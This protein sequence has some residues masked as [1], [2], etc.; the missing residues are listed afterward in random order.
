MIDIQDDEFQVE[1]PRGLP[2]PLPQDEAILWQSQPQWTALA[3]SAFHVVK[4]TAY[5]G[6]LIAWNTADGWVNGEGLGPIVVS[7]LRL[8]SVGAVAV[9]IL[10]LLAW[11]YA[12]STIYT[13]TDKRVIIRSGLAV[14]MT[15]NLPLARIEAAAVTR[16]ESGTGS[17]ALRPARPN[18][19]ALLALW[20]NAR[21]WSL[22]NPE[23]MLRCVPDIDGTARLVGQALLATGGS[24]VQAPTATATTGIE[25]PA[26]SLAA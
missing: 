5:F 18:R 9:A 23:P 22:N 1:P 4:V 7:G 24:A 25:L 6:V 2:A 14:P 12:R 13:L 21:P 8:A 26:G 11:L 20:P 16:G 3:R 10:A 15:V 17:I 19:I